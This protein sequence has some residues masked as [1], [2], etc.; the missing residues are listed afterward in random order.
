MKLVVISFNKNLDLNILECWRRYSSSASCNHLTN[1]AIFVCTKREA[2][3]ENFKIDSS[4]RISLVYQVNKHL[5]V[6]LGAASS[7]KVC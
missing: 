2:P 4:E 5:L 6:N 1:E 3:E 7:S